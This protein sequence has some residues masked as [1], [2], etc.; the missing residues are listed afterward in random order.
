M[1]KNFPYWISNIPG[2]RTNRKIC[3]F[4]SD[5]WGSIRMPYDK[6]YKD[7][8]KHNIINPRN[9]THYHIYDALE[10]NEDLSSLFDII[11]SFYDSNGNHPMFT[12]LNIIANPDFEKIRKSDFN[13]YYHEPFTKTL[14]RYPNHDKVYTL[15]LEGINNNLFIPQFHG[16]EHLNVSAWLKALKKESSKTKVAFTYGITGINPITIN[17]SSI[18]FQAAF[19]FFNKNELA[20]HKYII[21]E[22]TILFKKLM[23]YKPSY[24]VPPNGPFNHSL[25]PTLKQYGIDYLLLNKLQREPLGNSKYK[26]RINWLGKKNQNNQIILTRNASFEPSAG[27]KDWVNSCLKNIEIAFSTKKPAIISSHRVNYIGSLDSRNRTRNLKLLK[28]LLSKILF[29]WP[30][31]EFMSSVELGNIIRNSKN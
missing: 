25:C 13:E 1:K 3:V 26:T 19:D 30:D 16:R 10:S 15:L 4:E 18:Q 6:A 27:G 23:G 7:L 12:G 20:N 28:T 22:G 17:E 29:Y 5:D 21:E 11:H 9:L 24:F 31:V 14:K 2:W 8:I